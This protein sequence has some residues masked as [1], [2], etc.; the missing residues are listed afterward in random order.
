[1]P[2]PQPEPGNYPKSLMK[3]SEGNLWERV[4]HDGEDEKDARA[5]GYKL[6]IEIW[7]A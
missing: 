6:P 3:H 7:P 2:K 1:M 5:A 4:V